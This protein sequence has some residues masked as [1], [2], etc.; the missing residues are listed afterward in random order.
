MRHAPRSSS[1]FVSALCATALLASAC[2]SS[3][4]TDAA[5]ATDA[6]VTSDA[7]GTLYAR[8]GNRTG[9]AAA[10][11]AIVVRELADP[12]I[13]SYFYFQVTPGRSGMPPVDGHPNVAQLKSC[14]VNQ[15]ANAAGGP[16]QYPGTP[17][18]NAGWQCRDMATAHN[19]LNIPGSVFDRF[20]S[21]AA[22]ELGR[23]GVAASDIA[24]IGGVLNSTRASVAQGVTRDGGA[25]VR[26]DGG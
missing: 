2:S 12:E 7:G 21:I 5:V 15:L 25:F 4:T 20:V 1:F 19:G 10:V 22:S 14:L 24:I 6:A 23:L 11:D 3:S 9:I 26:P 18:D 16:E 8:L 17:A 13:A